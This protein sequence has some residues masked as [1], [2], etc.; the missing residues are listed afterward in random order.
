MIS[1]T[2]IYIHHRTNIHWLDGQRCYE[3]I[4]CHAEFPFNTVGLNKNKPSDISCSLCCSLCS[5]LTSNFFL[6]FI[7]PEVKKKKK[8]SESYSL[9]YVF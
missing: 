5:V 6:I 7:K 4:Y 9:S 2:F 3:D 1:L 8:K